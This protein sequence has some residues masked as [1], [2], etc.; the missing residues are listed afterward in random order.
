M[1]FGTFSYCTSILPDF[2][3]KYR[4]WVIIGYNLLHSQVKLTIPAVNAHHILNRQFS[5][6]ALVIMAGGDQSQVSKGKLKQYGSQAEVCK[7][8]F[9]IRNGYL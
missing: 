8:V 9:V 5:L 7:V 2:L 4:L 6:V 3:R 1:S